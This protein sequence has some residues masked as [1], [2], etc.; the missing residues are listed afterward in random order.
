MRCA[1]TIPIDVT[2]ASSYNDSPLPAEVESPTPAAA[3]IC[4]VCVGEVE[5]VASRLAVSL[6]IARP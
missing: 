3:E 4:E 1:C 2:Y 6:V 5:S